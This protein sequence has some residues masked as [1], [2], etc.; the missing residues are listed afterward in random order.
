MRLAEQGHGGH[1]NTVG[2][3][4]DNMPGSPARA[5]R[6]APGFLERQEELVPHEG[7]RRTRQRVPNLRVDLCDAVEKSRR[8][9]GHAWAARGLAWDSASV[10]SRYLSAS[11][12][13][14]HP[15]PAD[16]TA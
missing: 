5:R 1:R 14:M 9:V 8:P 16:V 11:S 2:I 12:A 13:A 15:V 4:D 7:L 6:G 3:I 10:C